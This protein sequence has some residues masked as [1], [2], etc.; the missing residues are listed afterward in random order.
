MPG[1]RPP[2]RSSANPG[3]TSARNTT[4]GAEASRRQRNLQKTPPHKVR[5]DKPPLHK[6]RQASPHRNNKPTAA[7]PR[8][9]VRVALLH[10]LVR[11]HPI[12]VP[13]V[14]RQTLAA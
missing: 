5:L 2:A 1:R 14:L 4:S 11:R 6:T 3:I 9:S 7:L 10:W 8:A 12:V 13:E